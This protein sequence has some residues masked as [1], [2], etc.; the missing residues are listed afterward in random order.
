MREPQGSTR[1]RLR[2]LT[3]APQ[4]SAASRLQ[5]RFG[6]AQLTS[7]I[8]YQYGPLG[9]YSESESSGPIPLPGQV[10]FAFMT[11]SDVVPEMT[12]M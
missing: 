6:P 12:S 11:T 9:P 1:P 10:S 2:V 3:S 5:R 8:R 4:A 7:R